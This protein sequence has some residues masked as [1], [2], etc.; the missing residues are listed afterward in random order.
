MISLSNGSVAMRK[1][2][3]VGVI[4]AAATAA[5]VPAQ[6][7]ASPSA[8]TAAT[9]G[10]SVKDNFFSPKKVTVGV[11]GKVR[12]TWRGSAPHNVTFTKVPR[13]ATKKGAG[14]RRK[15]SFTRSFG[16]RGTYRYV[17]TIHAGMTGTVVAK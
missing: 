17:C 11:R 7:L 13:G 10:V 4:A 2:L 9:K 8:G 6:L 16:K 12:W 5:I 3:V 15:G 14:T 1:L